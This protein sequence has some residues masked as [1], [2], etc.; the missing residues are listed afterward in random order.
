MKEELLLTIM[1]LSP[2]QMDVLCNAEIICAEYSSDGKYTTDFKGLDTAIEILKKNEN[3]HIYI[4]SMLPKQLLS[5]HGAEKA[6]FLLN[7]PRVSFIDI[8][9]LN[10]KKIVD[11]VLQQE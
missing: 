3:K 6:K 8:I 9:S 10:G 1:L 7:S 4:T 11:T 2:E 5:K